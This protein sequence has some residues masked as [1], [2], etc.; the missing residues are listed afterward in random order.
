M[1]L[2]LRYLGKMEIPH[3]HCRD[4]H[5]EGLLTGSA[6]RLTQHFHVRKH[7]QDAL[8]EAEV[9]DAAGNFAIFENQETCRRASCR[10]EFFHR[11]RLRGCTRGAGDQDAALGRAHHVLHV[12]ISAVKN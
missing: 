8:V 9:S 7:F 5:F 3:F 10:S 6:H 2:K 4:H 12:G 11:D 1:E